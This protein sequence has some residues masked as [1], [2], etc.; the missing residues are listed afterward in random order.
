ME[1][2]LAWLPYFIL[3]LVGILYHIWSKPASGPLLEQLKNKN[4]VLSVLAYC[5]LVFLWYDGTLEIISVEAA[6]S[7]LAFVLGYFSQSILG[8]VIKQ[9][10]DKLKGGNGN[11]PTS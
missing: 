2:I 1:T 7:G 8:H 3:G 9:V 5:V 4:T 6:P 11:A 10:G